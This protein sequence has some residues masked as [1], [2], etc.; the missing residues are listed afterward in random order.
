MSELPKPDLTL[1]YQ[2]SRSQEG[3][4][5]CIPFTEFYFNLDVFHNIFHIP[6]SWA[7]VLLVQFSMRGN[8][9]FLLSQKT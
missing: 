2:F 3:N 6:D 4:N 9:L 7:E 5:F 1:Q 8:W